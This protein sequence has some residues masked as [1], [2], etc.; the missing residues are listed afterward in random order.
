MC[1]RAVRFPQDVRVAT[2]VNVGNAPVFPGGFDRF[3][4]DQEKC[5]GMIAD[6]VLAFFRERS[7]LRLGRSCLSV[8]AKGAMFDEK[9]DLESI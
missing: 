2:V 9:L 1:A 5:G 6:A 8:F 7:W 3:E 4:H